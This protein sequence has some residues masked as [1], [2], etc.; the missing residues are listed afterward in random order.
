MRGREGPSC[1][2]DSFFFSYELF[3]LDFPSGGACSSLPSGNKVDGSSRVVCG[4][5]AVSCVAQVCESPRRKLG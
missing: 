5:M 3:V 1:S 4:V 2:L